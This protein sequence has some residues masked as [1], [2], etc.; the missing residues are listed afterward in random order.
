MFDKLLVPFLLIVITA[1]VGFLAWRQQCTMDSL[2]SARRQIDA[3]AALVRDRPSGAP[4]PPRHALRSDPAFELLDSEPEAELEPEPEM[5][6][7]PRPAMGQVPEP[8]TEQEPEPEMEQEPETE[9]VPG[10][11]VVDTN[12]H[13]PGA[14]AATFRPVVVVPKL[15]TV[16]ARIELF[17]MQGGGHVHPSSEEEG[18]LDPQS[19]SRLVEVVEAPE[20]GD[21]AYP[22]HPSPVPGDL[23]SVR[24]EGVDADS[25]EVGL[26]PPPSPSRTLTTVPDEAPPIP[27]PQSGLDSCEPSGDGAPVVSGDEYGSEAEP[28]MFEPEEKEVREKK[29]KAVDMSSQNFAKS[30]PPRRK[31]RQQK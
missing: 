27:G 16:A 31:R 25:I 13:V 12:Y 20:A 9:P 11:E 2:L 5:N 19:D 30:S 8:E 21:G 24:A 3:V 22:A 15:D 7:V 1:C 28:P 4:R 18:D 26:T 17:Q 23:D 29:S 6:H 10:R 14:A